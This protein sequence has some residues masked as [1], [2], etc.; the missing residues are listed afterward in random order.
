MTMLI[1]RFKDKTDALDAEFAE[2]V[3]G[4]SVALVGVS[5]LDNLEQGDFIDSHD[6]VARL[7]SPIPYPGNVGYQARSDL[8]IAPD[9]RTPSFVPDEWQSR[10]GKRVNVFYHKEFSPSRMKRLLHLFQNAGGEFLSVPYAANLW[11]AKCP[12]V[13]KMAS[14]RYLTND[15][16]LNTTEVVGDIV[17]AGSIVIADILRH[18]IQ[19]LYITGFPTM[20]EKDGILH[21]AVPRSTH[22]MGFKNFDWI[23]ELCCDYEEITTDSNMTALFDIVPNTWE[24]YRELHAD[25]ID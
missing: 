3:R 1:Y 19:S 21:S 4:K 5:A 2:Y 9:W 6:V 17:Y 13:R 23:R 16:F 7:H 22:Y 14:C 25:D 8:G 15:H 24:E 10:I 20:L 12:E 11:S 18:D